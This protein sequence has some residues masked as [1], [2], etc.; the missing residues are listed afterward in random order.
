MLLKET[1]RRRRHEGRQRRT[2]AGSCPPDEPHDEP[3]F[4]DQALAPYL[5]VGPTVLAVLVFLYG[6]IVASAVL[7]VARLESA[8]R[9]ISISS[10]PPI[11]PRIFASADFQLSPPGTRFS[12]ALILIPAQIV[13]PLI[14]AVLIYAVRGSRMDT[15]YRG[16]LFL[17]TIVAYSVAGVAWSWLLNPG[18]RPFQRSADGLRLPALALAHRS[19][20]GAALRIAG[21]L[22][23][24]RSASTCCCGW[25]R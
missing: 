16:M 21:H 10:V 3:A 14:L 2:A 15:V 6:P 7:S 20:S 17:P 12:T 5:F 8:C 23:E 22:L 9:R 13:I 11:T 18:Q 24:E 25:R 1:D 4:A 19:G